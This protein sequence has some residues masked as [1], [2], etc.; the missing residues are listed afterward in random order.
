MSQP[1]RL[2]MITKTLLAQ[3]ITQRLGEPGLKNAV[4]LW[5]FGAWWHEAAVELSCIAAVLRALLLLCCSKAQ[6]IQINALRNLISR[7]LSA[8]QG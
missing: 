6:Q 5:G 4:T 3:L 7:A 2:I 1:W 8:E